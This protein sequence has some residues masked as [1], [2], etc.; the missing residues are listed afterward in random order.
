MPR[1]RSVLVAYITGPEPVVS[2]PRRVMCLALCLSLSWSAGALAQ[3]TEPRAITDLYSTGVDAAGAPI[4]LGEPDMHWEVRE[5]S[6]PWVGA[7]YDKNNYCR[8]CGG[9][10]LD[11]PSG[12]NTLSRPLTH[13]DWVRQTASSRTFSWRTTF[14]LPPDADPAATSIT[15][16]V[17]FDDVSLDGAGGQHQYCP[18]TVWL[19][20]T[21]HAMNISGQSNMQ[22]G[23]EATL[24]PGVGFVRGA[25]TL[26]FRILNL[27]TYYGFRWELVE[28]TAMIDTRPDLVVALTSPTPGER[29]SDPRPM[30]E[31]ATQPGASVAVDITT[32]G[33]VAVASPPASVGPQGNFRA[34]APLL[35]DGAY[36]VMATASDDRGGV[37]DGPRRFVI[38]TTP[39]EITITSPSDGQ[40]VREARPGLWGTAEPGAELEVTLTDELGLVA[41][42]AG[43]R[44]RPE[45]EWRVDPDDALPEGRYRLEASATDEVGNATQADPVTFEIRLRMPE[46]RLRS[47]ADGEVVSTPTPTLA[48]SARDVDAL[49]VLLDGEVIGVAR[50]R[51][52][53]QW[54]FGVPEDQ[55]LAPGAHTLEAAYLDRWG[56]RYSSGVHTITFE[57]PGADVSPLRVLSPTEGARLEVGPVEISGTGEPA[58]A[59]A[60]AASAQSVSA[61]IGEDGSWSAE[62]ESL[63]VGPHIL[64]VTGAGGEVV[65]V[66]VHIE[67]PSA[68]EG[69]AQ[70]SGDDP[71]ASDLDSTGIEEQGCAC[72]SAPGP[73]RSTGELALLLVGLWGGRWRRRQR[74][75]PMTSK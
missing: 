30:I 64:I 13:S 75:R 4:A 65:T 57:P 24:A 9:S 31:G 32:E 51:A 5:G 58:T 34:R 11:H 74:T 15:Y 1:A 53:G 25:N 71:S 55:A 70:G 17:G 67:D 35:D 19:N 37:S 52:Q 50:P 16:R 26:E 72:A 60:V 39:P 14:T 36:Q 44:A 22:T 62:L 6:G 7:L 10:W 48:G 18:H 46:V 59:V 20:G 40:I 33:G 12:D 29:M 54:S 45:G 73:A 63:P 27:A 56:D 42:A 66:S 49:D 2:H 3:S 69:E 41:Y 8:S 61:V 43:P 28:A 38:D 47:P 21:P 23:C 68:G